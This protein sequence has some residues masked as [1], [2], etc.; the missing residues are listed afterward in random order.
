M[1]FRFENWKLDTA[2]YELR[3]DGRQCL[4]E[5]QAFNILAF[6]LD[7]SDRV[8]SRDELL[9]EL[10]QGRVV[11]DA[12][13]STGIKL[14][15]Q[16]IGDNGHTQRLIKT[17]HGRGF[18]FVGEVAQ[19]GRIVTPLRAAMSTSAAP[20]LTAMALLP[21]DVFSNDPELE[22]FADGLVEDLTTLLART[23]GLL[24]ISRSSS[25]AYKGTH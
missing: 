22:Y 10:W 19:T 21:F 23:P 6:L 1:I 20:G 12:T 16:A 5:P 2:T 7:N 8:V 25:F 15:R 9:E 24:V 3:Q 17:V 14:A 13:L 11:S 18:R 4:L